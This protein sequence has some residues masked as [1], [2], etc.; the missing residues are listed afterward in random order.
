MTPCQR[1]QFS[2][3]FLPATPSSPSQTLEGLSELTRCPIKAPDSPRALL[4]KLRRNKDTVMCAMLGPKV[5]G[6][7]QKQLT[8]T[9]IVR[10]LETH[11]FTPIL[12]CEKTTEL[13]S[14]HT[15]QPTPG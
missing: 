6:Y 5:P 1:R 11:F 3:L 14:K 4:P 12:D 8:Q 7:C 15:W 9:L 2:L 13:I 10:L